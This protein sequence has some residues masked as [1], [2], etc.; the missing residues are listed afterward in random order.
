VDGGR[1]V[2]ERRDGR[3]DDCDGLEIRE[4]G[5]GQFARVSLCAVFSGVSNE[6]SFGPY[7]PIW[8]RFGEFVTNP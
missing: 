6:T 7:Q 4:L 3:A 2:G 1:Y 8:S 5:V